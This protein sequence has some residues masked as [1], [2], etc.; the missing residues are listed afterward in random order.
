M[1]IVQFGRTFPSFSIPLSPLCLYFPLCRTAI[2][3]RSTIEFT[4][5]DSQTWLA[6]SLRMN[7]SFL[8]ASYQQ[9][10]HHLPVS[11]I[12]LSSD[13][14][15]RKRRRREE[16]CRSHCDSLCCTMRGGMAEECQT[17][18]GMNCSTGGRKEKEFATQV[19]LTPK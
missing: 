7:R 4:G 17:R 5:C 13:P 16:G 1:N 8:A 2:P 3:G 11:P 9:V 18:K 15:R 6:V 12:P 19:P 10:S 14:S